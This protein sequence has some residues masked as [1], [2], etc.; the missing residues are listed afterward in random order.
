MER[1]DPVLVMVM[2]ILNQNKVI[3]TLEENG[4]DGERRN[5]I[6]LNQNKKDE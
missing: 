2:M 6:N 3:I 1:A 5:R 4:D